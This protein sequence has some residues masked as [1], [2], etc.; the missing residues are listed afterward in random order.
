MYFTVSIP[1]LEKMVI[2]KTETVGRGSFHI[3]V[4]REQKSHR[5]PICNERTNRVRI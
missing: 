3:H 5:C 4:E 2:K 1:G